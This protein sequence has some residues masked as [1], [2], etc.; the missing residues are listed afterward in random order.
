MDSKD[1][2]VFFWKKDGPNGIFSNWSNHSIYDNIEFK[3]L[4]HYLM[5]SKACLFEDYEIANQI[6]K[7]NGPLT[8]K[9]LGRQV[10]NFNEKTWLANRHTIM[11][12]GLQMKVEQNEDVKE[13]LLAT[14]NKIIVEASPFDTIWGIGMSESDKNAT[15]T[16]KWKGL[17]LLGQA[18]MN[19]RDII[20]P[21]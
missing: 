8:V 1:N 13:A 9:N 17:N 20:K 15:D 3:T 2:F 10:K 11:Q 14:G 6:I 21:V 18:W 19:V 16:T 12:R 5:Y 7:A 4:E